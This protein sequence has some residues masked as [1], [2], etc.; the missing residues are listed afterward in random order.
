MTF[1]SGSLLLFSGV[2]SSFSGPIVRPVWLPFWSTLVGPVRG[3]VAPPFDNGSSVTSLSSTSASEGSLDPSEDR[4][5]SS[6]ATVASVYGVGAAMSVK[7]TI[8]P[9]PPPSSSS[10]SSSSSFVVALD[11]LTADRLEYIGDAPTDDRLIRF[12]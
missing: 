9:M 2:S 1:V 11:C 12:F 7:G 8:R 10:S 3:R 4:Q 5:P 6:P